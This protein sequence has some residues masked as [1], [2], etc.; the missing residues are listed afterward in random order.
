[1]LPLTPAWTDLRYHPEQARLWRTTARFVAVD[2]GRGSGKSEIA[3][4]RVVRMLNIKRPWSDPEYFY[5]LPTQ[6]QARLKHWDKI[7]AL[8]PRRWIRH[9]DEVRMVITT[10]YGSKLSLIGLDKPH[11]AEGAQ[12]DGGVIDESSDVRPKVFDLTFR[13]ALT[14]RNGWCWRIGVPKRYGVGAREFRSA[15]DEWGN[16][17]RE[18]AHFHWSSADILTPEQIESERAALDE[19][20]FSEQYLANWE[21][22]SGQIYYSFDKGTTIK[23]WIYRPDLPIFV[24]SDFNVNPMGWVL[25][26]AHG[27]TLHAFD[28]IW[29]KNTNTQK[30]LDE[31][32]RRYAG[33]KGGWRFFGDASGRGRRSSASSTDYMQIANDRRF[34]NATVHYPESN[35]PIV[36]RYAAVNWALKAANGQQTLFVDGRCLHLLEDLEYL[37]YREG[38]READTRDPDAGHI[39]DGLGYVIHKL[40]PM[41]IE[42]EQRSSRVA[43]M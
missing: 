7:K 41:R 16:M 12:Y 10:I 23:P 17:G 1:M 34:I 26:Q 29:L 15:C 22:A 21:M 36:D 37:S 25:L 39:S 18:Y 38:T 24:G 6:D 31:L 3:R 28:E 40:K 32:H 20:D 43:A 2:C 35:P 14:H 42:R 27:Q 19:R 5:A 30:T 11:R 33:H 13:P 4:R 9:K 8:I